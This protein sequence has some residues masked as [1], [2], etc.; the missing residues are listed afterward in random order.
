[1]EYKG[2]FLRNVKDEVDRSIK[3]GTYKCQDRKNVVNTDVN[4]W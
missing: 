3:M 2:N 1:M 4:F